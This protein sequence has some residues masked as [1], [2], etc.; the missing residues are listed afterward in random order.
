MS[1]KVQDIIERVDV[2][3]GEK[4]DLQC[5]EFVRKQPKQKKRR[6]DVVKVCAVILTGMVVVIGIGTLKIILGG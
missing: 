2:P 1:I 6:I 5:W 4:M 3:T